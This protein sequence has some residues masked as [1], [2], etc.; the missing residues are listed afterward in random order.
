MNKTFLHSDNPIKVTATS[1]YPDFYAVARSMNDKLANLTYDKN[2]K[3]DQLY[4]Q[5][6]PAN[7]ATQISNDH[8]SGQHEQQQIDELKQENENLS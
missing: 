6:G 1:K 5:A 3:L 7:F 8:F 4:A 2:L